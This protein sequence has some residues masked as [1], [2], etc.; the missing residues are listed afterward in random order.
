M[1]SQGEGFFDFAWRMSLQHRDYFRNR[2]L[3]SEREALFLEEAEA[4][5]LQ[6]TAIEAADK[7][8]FDQFLADYFA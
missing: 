1:R 6:Q 8:S 3:S 4:S 2:R 7:I 5:L